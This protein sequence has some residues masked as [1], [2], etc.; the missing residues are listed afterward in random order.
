MGTNIFIVGWKS[1]DLKSLIASKPVYVATMKHLPQEILDDL[2]LMHKDFIW[3]GKRDKIEH[4]TLIRDCI[5]G[6]LKD[7]DLVS[8]FT[9]L[10]FIWI[11]RMP[12]TKSLYLWIAV[13]DNILR[14]V[15]GVMFS[16]QNYLWHQVY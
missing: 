2:Q 9:S 11:K 3:D 10:K 4:C 14:N 5:D 15:G 16:T 1:S 13:A 8:K 6:G 12:D 7:V